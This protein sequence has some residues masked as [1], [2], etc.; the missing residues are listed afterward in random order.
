MSCE[1][2]LQVQRSDEMPTVIARGTERSEWFYVLRYLLTM[3]TGVVKL[4]ESASSATT[5]IKW[6]DPMQQ[7]QADY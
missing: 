7:Y 1:A 2:N 3:A 6:A 5:H 4:N